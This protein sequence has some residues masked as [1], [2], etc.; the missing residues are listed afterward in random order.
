MTTSSED[1]QQ[2]V[3]VLYEVH[4]KLRSTRSQARSDED[5]QKAWQEHTSDLKTLQ[6]E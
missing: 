6:V 1:Q 5:W 2:L 4:D 3:S